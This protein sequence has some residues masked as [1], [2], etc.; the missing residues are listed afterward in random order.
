M[1]FMDLT[2]RFNDLLYRRTVTRLTR[3]ELEIARAWTMQLIR[4][5]HPRWSEEEVERDYE[6]LALIRV[7]VVDEWS[8]RFGLDPVE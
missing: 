5:S 1:H 7:E 4:D 2:S 6:R 8:K 3:S